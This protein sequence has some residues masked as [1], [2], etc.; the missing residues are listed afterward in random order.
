[1]RAHAFQRWAEQL[2][3]WDTR[4]YR[5]LEQGHGIY[6]LGVET[7]NSIQRL[8]PVLHHG[9]FNLLELAGLHRNPAWII[10]SDRFVAAIDEYRPDVVVS[11]HA[12]LN[13]GYFT[14]ARRHL[15]DDRVR[16][17]TY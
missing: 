15:G 11:T 14:L 7:Y 10:G 1:M 3:D 4:V 9:Y 13:H 5:P 17:I 8:A 6:R 12:H 16:C 2:T